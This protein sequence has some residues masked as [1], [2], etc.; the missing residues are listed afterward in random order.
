MLR[1]FEV[2][3]PENYI[4]NGCCE[5]LFFQSWTMVTQEKIDA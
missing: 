2:F 3:N 1:G 4:F 5:L